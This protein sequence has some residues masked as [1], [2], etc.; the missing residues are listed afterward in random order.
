MDECLWRVGLDGRTPCNRLDRST[1]LEIV[2]TVTGVMREAL[3]AGGTSF[4]ALYV[5]V[6]KRRAPSKMA[7][8]CSLEPPDG[9]QPLVTQ[10]RF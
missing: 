3:V 9:K 6:K 5:N 4:D 8:L 1:A 7:Q 10:A 2:T